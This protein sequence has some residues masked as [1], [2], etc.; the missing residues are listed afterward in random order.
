MEVSD[1]KGVV[2]THTYFS[3]LFG[4]IAISM[5]LLTHFQV[6]EFSVVSQAIWSLWAIAVALSP[7]A[8]E[9]GIGCTINKTE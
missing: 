8:V 5:I 9:V 4:I 6:Y 2:I 7:I 1:K 3:M